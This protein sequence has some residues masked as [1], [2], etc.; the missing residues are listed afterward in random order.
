MTYRDPEGEERFERVQVVDWQ[1]PGNNDFLLVQQLWVTGEVYTRRADLVGF[2]NGLP[3]LFGELKAHHRRVKDAYR[4]NLSDYKDTVPHLLWYNAFILLSNGSDARIGTVTSEW[5]HFG[6]WKKINDEGEQ[7]VISLETAVRGTC[8]P[9][10]FLDIVEN[11]LIFQER[12]G[13]LAKIVA[14]YHQYFGVENAIEA[15]RSIR[16]NQGRLGVFWH[17]QG[18]GKSISMIFF[19]QKVHRKVHGNW[20]FL[21]I[22][23]RIDLDDQTYKNFAR[24]GVVTE[25]E[26]RVR[27]Q[28]GEHLQQLL[29]EDHRYLFTLIQKFQTRRDDP[30]DRLY[31]D[32]LYPKLSDRADII[33]ITDEAHRSQYDLLAMNMRHALPN[34]AFLAFTA[35][36]LIV[37]YVGMFRDLR[38]ALAIY[39]TGPGG[40]IEEGEE[41]V[42]DK[43]ALVERLSEAVA[44]AETFCAERGVDLAPITN[45]EGFQRVALMDDAVEQ[46]I[47]NDDLKIEYL[48][49]AGEVDRL[50]KAVL[51]DTRAG[52]FGPKRHVLIVLADKIRSL[53][54]AADIA[55][56]ITQV[57]D[58]LDES[59]E[60]KE[61]LIRDTSVLYD[62]SGID[63]DALR[64]QFERGRKAAWTTSKPSKSS[65]MNTT[66]APATSSS[67]LTNWSSSLSNSTR[68]NSAPSPRT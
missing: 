68:R 7:G 67:S 18:S 3:L 59:V 43:D 58:L 65:S 33:V 62:L 32:R 21:V 54:S 8:A 27:A 1:E 61:Y 34:A 22:T 52:E 28:S 24:A 39:G 17:T 13:G 5:E 48:G 11:Y 50:F 14:K 20:T 55:G 12:R 9:A 42:E 45:S 30:A 40:R 46:I 37:D 25:P 47:V 49:L 26:T 4:R 23:D 66:P 41:P 2:V 16:E 19:C 29:R 35:T 53:A 6:Q 44:A 31:P 56:V 63:F 38:R 36:P 51:P 57:E 60:A 15:V 64:Q 10:R